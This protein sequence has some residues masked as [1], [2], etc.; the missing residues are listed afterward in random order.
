MLQNGAPP[1]AV[2]QQQEVTAQDRRDIERLAA[3]RSALARNG[4]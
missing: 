1:A 4:P 3:A 2:R